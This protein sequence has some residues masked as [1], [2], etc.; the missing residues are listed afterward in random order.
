MRLLCRI[1]VVA[2]FASAALGMTKGWVAL[3]V[4]IG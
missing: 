2:L 3:S 1:R 4:E